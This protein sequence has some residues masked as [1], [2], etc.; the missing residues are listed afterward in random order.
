MKKLNIKRKFLLFLLL[1]APG[2]AYAQK[3]EKTEQEEVTFPCVTFWN[4]L[5][6][7]Y[8]KTQFA[9]SIGVVSAGVGWNYGKGHWETDALFGLVPRNTDRHAMATFTLKQNYLPW[10][11][12]LGE[13]FW[14]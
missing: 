7:R 3:T 12:D 2:L 11:I 13:N 8:I 4:K 1:I 9:G 5:I 14:I 6:P 10:K